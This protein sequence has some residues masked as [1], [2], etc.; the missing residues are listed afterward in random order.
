MSPITSIGVAGMRSAAA[1][2]EAAAA[3]V[4]R[5]GTAGTAPDAAREIDLPTM[6]VTMSLASYDFEAS[7]KV[8]MI[9][10][11]LMQAALDMVA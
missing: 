7:V 1:R 4:V 11:D 6:M 10:R 8:A 5:A 3:G 9:G 2:F